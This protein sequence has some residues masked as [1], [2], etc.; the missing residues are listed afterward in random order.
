MRR[1]SAA[2]IKR[3]R[4]YTT[5]ELAECCGVHKNTVRN[6]QRDG[7]APID[8]GRPLLFYGADV[9]A[10]LDARNANKKQ[11]CKPG[12]IYCFGCRAPGRPACG[13]V[14]YLPMTAVGGNLRAQCASCGTTMHRRVR[15]TEIPKVL[16]GWTVDV[17]EGQTRLS[18]N[19]DPS[20]NCDSNEKG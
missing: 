14:E 1:I 16:P 3:L 4:S 15:M 13:T 7:L 17:S 19:A 18:G 20:L 6:W 5:Y 10:F 8:P 2:R 11:P 12:T 9:R